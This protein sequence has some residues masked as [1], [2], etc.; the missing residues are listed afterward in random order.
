MNQQINKRRATGAVGRGLFKEQQAS[1]VHCDLNESKVHIPAAGRNAEYTSAAQASAG[2][3]KSSF[4]PVDK[5]NPEDDSQEQSSVQ[6]Y[7]KYKNDVVTSTPSHHQHLAKAA[8]PPVSN[9]VSGTVSQGAELYD[10]F[11]NDA[12]DSDSANDSLWHTK[13]N[14]PPERQ[15]LSPGRS[16]HVMA[17][18][19]LS[20]PLDYNTENGHSE[21]HPGHTLP[22]WRS[23]SPDI[24]SLEPPG[25]GSMSTPYGGERPDGGER[26]MVPRVRLSSPKLLQDHQIEVEPVEAEE[27]QSA[28][29]SRTKS[30]RTRVIRMDQ[31]TINCD[32]CDIEVSNGKELE[33]H[34]DSKI[35]WDIMEHIQQQNNYDDMTIAFL[36]D[37]ML[38]KSIKCSRAIDD[39]SLLALQENDHMTKVALFHCAACQVLVSTAA[40][41][42]QNHIT[43]PEHL[44]NTKEFGAQRRHASLDKADTIMKELQPQFENF[45][46]GFSQFE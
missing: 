1:R 20:R 5:Q 3:W 28:S 32:L 45:L 16:S 44:S 11:D 15:R 38:Y 21:S 24:K 9:I 26:M 35:H 13:D 2:K 42:V 19:E 8:H 39:S 12:V 46:K 18:W 17:S 14:F 31:I 23:Y 36:Q 34:L 43:S 30:E 27:E 25:Y 22:E 29:S 40:S 6:R 7:E 10:P 37:V 41:S 33:D 4:K